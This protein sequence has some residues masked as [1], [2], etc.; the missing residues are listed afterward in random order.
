MSNCFAFWISILNL[1]IFFFSLLVSIIIISVVVVCIFATKKKKKKML[2]Q[3]QIRIISIFVELNL[4][5]CYDCCDYDGFRCLFD[6]NYVSTIRSINSFLN[7]F[8]F[9]SMFFFSSFDFAYK[10]IG[11][12]ATIIGFRMDTHTFGEKKLVHTHTHSL[13]RNPNCLIL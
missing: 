11:I 3:N 4:R 9:N 12:S 1:F 13:I 10:H 8:R 5:F 7:F 2:F 6:S